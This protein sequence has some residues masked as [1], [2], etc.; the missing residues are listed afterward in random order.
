MAT[1]DQIFDVRLRI[2]DPPGFIA[3]EE[4]TA[5]P[6]SP[7]PQTCY[8]LSGV[9][10]STEKTT[11]AV[12]G[13]YTIEEL[14]VSDVRI[15][16]WIDLNGSDYATCQSIKSIISQIGRSL[17]IKRNSTGADSTEYQ[18]LADTL[19]YYKD[20]LSLC[21]EEK[22]ANSGNNSGRWGQTKQPEIGGGNL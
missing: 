21:T 15:G 18:T 14:M 10:Y 4:V 1:T 22:Q 13:D 19:A 17:Q 20:L 9:Y 5:L 3:F 2:S 12:A 8:L 6:S 7:S 16:N 11:G